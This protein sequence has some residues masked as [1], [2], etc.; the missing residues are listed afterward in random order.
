MHYLLYHFC[1]G[2]SQA[3]KYERSPRKKK[4]E[5]LMQMKAYVSVNSATRLHA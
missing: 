5:A 1:I 2:T 4:E 3:K